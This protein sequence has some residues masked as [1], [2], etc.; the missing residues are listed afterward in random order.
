M[1]YKDPQAARLASRERVRRY[2]KRQSIAKKLGPSAVEVAGDPADVLAAWSAATLVVPAGHP[3]AGQAMTLPPYGVEFLRDALAPGVRES[4]LT[5]GRKN[6]KSAIVAVLTLGLLAGPLRRPGL[7]IGTVS[8]TREKAGELLTQCRDI[9]EAS[10]LAGLEFMRT[11]SPGMVRGA[12]GT[13][14]DFLSA[15]KSSGHASGFDLAIID[16]LGLMTERDR[17]LVAGMRTSTS[18][19]DGRLLAIS[20]RGECPMLE[21]LLQRADLATCAVHMYAPETPLAGDV[22]VSDPSVWAAANPGL[23]LGIKS[24]AWMADEAAR[25]LQTPSDLSSFLALDLNLPQ[26]PGREM[27]FAPEDLTGCFVPDPPE[28]A[29]PCYVGFDF[30][31]AAALSAA[32]AIWPQTGRCE[33]W[34]ACGD[35]PDLVSRGRRDGARYDLMVERGELRTYPDA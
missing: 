29:G 9:A 4:L 33:A 22:D 10:E 14:A 26:T 19:R 21:E 8:V 31:G 5:M 25:V 35:V 20:V 34:A 16:E 30:G 2:R 18:A 13:T 23:E 17:E 12:D 28:R 24:A 32:F 6:A 1:P 3:N 27:I 15:D 11:P 7:R